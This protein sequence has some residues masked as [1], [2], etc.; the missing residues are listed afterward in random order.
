MIAVTGAAGFIG[1]AVIWKLNFEGREDIIAVDELSR[2]DSEKKKNLQSVKYRELLGKDDFLNKFKAG[3]FPGIKNIIHLGACSKTTEADK[4]YLLENNYEYTKT[5][6]RSSLSAGVRFI[7][8]SSAATYGDGSRGFSDDHSR[9][10][11]Y[12]PLNIYGLSKHLFDLWAKKNKLLDKI[13]GLK[14]FNV[15]GP[16][17]YHKEEMRSFVLKAYE[18][19]K[20]TGQVGLFKSYR[21]DYAHGEQKRDFLY[22]KDAVEM[23]L[24]FLDNPG[25]NGIYNIGT[26]QPRTW[27]NLAAAVFKAM[28]RE[29]NIKYI[30]MPPEIKDKYQY[31]T[32]AEMSKYKKAA[33]KLNVF[34]L[35]EGVSDYVTN[36]LIPSKRL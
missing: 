3:S 18:Q 25:I 1:S 2:M 31:Y 34:S 15:Y 10:E 4:I 23:T 32:A 14:Y 5:L 35:E 26:G 20:K 27:N 6:A 24:F 11:V 21:P 29:V 16:N 17:E 13:A 30:D 8:A 12:E 7:Y 28:D 9:L 33:K 19:I 22:I 36:Y